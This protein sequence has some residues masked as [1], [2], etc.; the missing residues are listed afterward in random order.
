[1]SLLLAMLPRHRTQIGQFL[2]FGA[3]TAFAEKSAPVRP[4]EPRSNCSLACETELVGFFLMSGKVTFVSPNMPICVPKSAWRPGICKHMHGVCL[5]KCHEW[6]TFHSFSLFSLKL[7]FRSTIVGPNTCNLFCPLAKKGHT[8]VWWILTTFSHLT[9][10]GRACAKG[11][12][13]GVYLFTTVCSVGT[14]SDP[15]KTNIIGAVT[16]AV[17]EIVNCIV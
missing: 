6:I 4:S 14:S 11:S 7:V 9:H 15:H 12:H 13:H 3:L 17:S 16:P 2:I 1:M 8:D 10:R 5:P